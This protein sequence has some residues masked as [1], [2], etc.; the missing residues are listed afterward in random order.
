M[1]AERRD[2]TVATYS[3]ARGTGARLIVSTLTGNGC[4]AGAFAS[5]LSHPVLMKAAASAT[6]AR[7]ASLLNFRIARSLRLN[8]YLVKDARCSERDSKPEL[9]VLRRS[10]VRI[11]FVRRCAI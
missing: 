5:V 10:S 11:I 3:S 2:F 1:L 9:S 8:P 6:G 4:G 7:T